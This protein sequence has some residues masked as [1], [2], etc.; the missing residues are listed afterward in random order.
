MSAK[1]TPGPWFIKDGKYIAAYSDGYEV[2]IGKVNSWKDAP[3]EA[4]AN[5]HLF[6]AAPELLEALQEA[7]ACLLMLTDPE[8]IQRARVQAA[9]AIAVA[10]EAKA[11]AAIQKATAGENE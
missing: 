1:H 7:Q 5:S 4:A 3:D 2:E 9:W 10:T 11:R 6:A 8:R